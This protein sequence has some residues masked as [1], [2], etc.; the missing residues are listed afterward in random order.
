MGGSVDL[1]EVPVDAL[2]KEVQRRMECAN[3]PEKRIILIG[4][5]PL[6]RGTLPA[7]SLTPAV[8]TRD[9]GPPG[10][11]KGTQSPKIKVC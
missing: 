11:G 8:S 6:P 1:S 4:A 10:C 2:V 5:L 3:K 7:P 9:A